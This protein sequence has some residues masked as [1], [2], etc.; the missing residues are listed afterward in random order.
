[1]EAI[2]WSMRGKLKFQTHLGAMRLLIKCL[3]QEFIDLEERIESQ[4]GLSSKRSLN[5]RE[6]LPIVENEP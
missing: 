4:E 5:G 2:C 1:M 6:S 3:G